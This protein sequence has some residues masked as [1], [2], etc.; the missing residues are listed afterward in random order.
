MCQPEIEQLMVNMIPTGDKRGGSSGNTHNNYPDRIVDWY[1]EVGNRN[2]RRVSVEG[3]QL[4][5]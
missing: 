3:H 1:D 4:R 2:Q 5:V